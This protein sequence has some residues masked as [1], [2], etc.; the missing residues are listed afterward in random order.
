MTEAYTKSNAR[1]SKFIWTSLQQNLVTKPCSF[2]HHVLA[3]T[4]TLVKLLSLSQQRIQLPLCLTYTKLPLL[5]IKCG[6]CMQWTRAAI[7]HDNS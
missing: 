5:F 7:I 3:V 2:C 4:H 1:G 6:L